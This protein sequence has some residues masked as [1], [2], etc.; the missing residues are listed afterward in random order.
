MIGGWTATAAQPEVMAPGTTSL[1]ARQRTQWLLIRAMALMRVVQLSPWPIAVLLGVRSGYAHP[2]LATLSYVVQSGWGIAFVIMIMRRRVVRDW[3][4][5]VDSIVATGCLIAAGWACDPM[6]VTSWS[7]S[8]VAPAM[9]AAMA[10]AVFWPLRPAL[11]G[12]V[13]IIIGYVVGIAPGIVDG[14]SAMASAVGNVL[15][16]SGF[17]AVG[18][19]IAHYLLKEA[20]RVDSA[21]QE[22]VAER[23]RTAAQRARFDERTRQY[24]MLH[25]TVLSTLSGIARGGLDHQDELVRRRCA[26]DADYLRGLIS[27]N[28]DHAPSELSAA[29]ARVGRDQVALGLRVHHNAADL[30]TNIPDDVVRALADAAREALN[31][32]TKHAGSAEAWVTAVAAADVLTVTVVDQGAGFDPA[33]IPA[34][35]GI[36][37]S[38][39]DR[40]T[41]VG[42]SAYVDSSPGQGTTVEL[43]WPA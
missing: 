7:D 39:R 25:D 6:F 9:G 19:M 29:L 20:D 18:A 13:P 15:S 4:V 22:V 43:R 32:V 37:G 28:H 36:S 24:R 26:G 27:G 17:V 14:P 2:L 3:M 8:A 34:G 5:V 38:I 42:G 23:E 40:M 33:F 1:G 10:V 21:T 30:P 41:E 11:A 35:R 12:T 31:N 16:L